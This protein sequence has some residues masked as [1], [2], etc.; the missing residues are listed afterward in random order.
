MFRDQKIKDLIEAARSWL[1]IPYQRGARPRFSQE[2]AALNGNKPAFADCSSLVVFALWSSTGKSLIPCSFDIAAENGEDIFD[3]SEAL[4]G[5]FL[6][7]KGERWKCDYNR[8]PYDGIGHVAI[9]SY[10]NKII[11]SCNSEGKT[12]VVEHTFTK[13][14]HLLYH[15]QSIVVIKRFI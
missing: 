1:G 8:L 9:L 5:D 10:N 13:E 6:L 4:P 7:F 2:F 12:G 3:F 14:E 15:P 11:H